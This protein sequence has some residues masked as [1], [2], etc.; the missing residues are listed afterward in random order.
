MLAGVTNREKAMDHKSTPMTCRAAH[1]DD[2]RR[3]ERLCP[4][5]PASLRVKS[6]LRAGDGGSSGGGGG[7]IFNHN[8]SRIARP[9]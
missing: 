3:G 6:G 7:I 1:Q 9:R 8:R 5:Y 2:A 4:A